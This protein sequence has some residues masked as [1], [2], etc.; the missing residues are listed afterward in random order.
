M[1]DSSDDKQVS[2]GQ[3]PTN[4]REWMYYKEALMDNGFLEELENR[5]IYHMA[6]GEQ[7]LKYAAIRGQCLELAKMIAALC[8]ESRER[9]LAFTALEE[10]MFW[11]NASVARN[12]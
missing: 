5:F 4:Y 8:P 7:P 2:K 3:V 11:A 1:T 10:A 6:E 9:S 12:T